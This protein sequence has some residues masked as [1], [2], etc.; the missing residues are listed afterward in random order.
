SEEQLIAYFSQPGNADK[1]RDDFLFGLCRDWWARTQ[2]DDFQFVLRD[3]ALFGSGQPNVLRIGNRGST[4]ELLMDD[5]FN[6]QVITDARNQLVGMGATP[7]GYGTSRAGQK[8]PKFLVFAPQKFVDP[9]EDE[10]KFREA[11]LN[12]Q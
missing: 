10:Q 8:I 4:T 6:T 2:C 3:K 9:L 12:N 11:V 5:T 7:M 1:N